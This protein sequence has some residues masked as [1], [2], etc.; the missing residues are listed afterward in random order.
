MLIKYLIVWDNHF[1]YCYINIHPLALEHHT[2]PSFPYNL[3]W[4][5]N[6]VFLQY[7][8]VVSSKMIN[9]CQE[10]NGTLIW[11]LARKWRLGAKIEVSS[12]LF[13][14]L[15]GHWPFLGFHFLL[16]YLFLATNSYERVS[17]TYFAG[18]AASVAIGFRL[19]TYSIT[20][21]ICC[22]DSLPES[23]H[24][25]IVW[26]GLGPD[27]TDPCSTNRSRLQTNT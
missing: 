22:G 26:A 6:L 5:F 11:I 7:L 4:I 3:P 15:F 18:V 19:M 1:F 23:P 12:L 2:K 20:S 17:A 24:G 14:S 13:C 27:G 10:S 8:D 21:A 9:E 16:R 25:T